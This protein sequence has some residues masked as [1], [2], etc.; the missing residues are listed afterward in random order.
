MATEIRVGHISG[1]IQNRTYDDFKVLFLQ[2]I[3]DEA[4]LQTAEARKQTLEAIKQTAVLERL[5]ERAM[6]NGFSL[7]KRN[8]K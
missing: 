7:A 3:R 4:K 6:R 8:R 1:I 5:D 2:E